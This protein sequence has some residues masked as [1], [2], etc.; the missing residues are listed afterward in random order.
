MTTNSK[1][2][3]EHWYPLVTDPGSR[4]FSEERKNAKLLQGY[5]LIIHQHL[6]HEIITVADCEK[7]LCVTFNPISPIE[8]I[9]E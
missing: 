1:K 8:G 9:I 2:R 3:V 4:Y 5:T 7:Y 6:A